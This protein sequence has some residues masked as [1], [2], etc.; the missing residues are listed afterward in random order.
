[1][2]KADAAHVRQGEIQRELAPQYIDS[3]RPNSFGNSEH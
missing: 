1:M 2:A 3:I